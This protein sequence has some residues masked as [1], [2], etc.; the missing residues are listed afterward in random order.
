MRIPLQT[1]V[2]SSPLDIING[3]ESRLDTANNLHLDFRQLHLRPVNAP[4][5]IQHLAD[6]VEVPLL[7][8][9]LAWGQKAVADD[10]GKLLQVA[11]V[12]QGKADGLLIAFHEVT[13]GEG[14]LADALHLRLAL[15]GVLVRVGM[16]LKW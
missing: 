13:H 8:V 10:Q 12:A 9:A 5:R 7:V 14:H 6:L 2:S 11:K 4:V 16:E 3:Q 15:V 1:R